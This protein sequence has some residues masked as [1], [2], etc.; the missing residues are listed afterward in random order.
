MIPDCFYCQIPMGYD[1]YYA[2]EDE[3]SGSFK[4]LQCGTYF[5]FYQKKLIGVSIITFYQGKE[6]EFH[7][8]FRSSWIWSGDRLILS[9][10]KHQTP[11]I[12]PN[13][14]NQKLKTA[15]SFL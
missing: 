6:Y 4:C 3:F 5:E 13:N 8:N 11:N 7:Y 2:D 9:F 1:F 15:L 10:K 12:C 14:F